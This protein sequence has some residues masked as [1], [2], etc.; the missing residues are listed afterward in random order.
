MDSG[1]L[2]TQIAVRQPG[3]MPTPDLMDHTG[4]EDSGSSQS[5]V[6]E[7]SMSGLITGDLSEDAKFYQ[8]VAVE[9]QTTYDTL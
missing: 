6:E 5:R 7:E 4:P 3:P 9:L 8:D 2:A 1:D